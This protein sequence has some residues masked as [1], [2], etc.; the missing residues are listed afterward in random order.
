MSDPSH[1]TDLAEQ[2]WDAAESTT[3][4]EAK[5]VMLEIA[6]TYLRQADRASQQPVQLH[7][8]NGKP[9]SMVEAEDE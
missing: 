2:A 7:S 4:L 5:T 8:L 6:A 9:A 1:W 3:E